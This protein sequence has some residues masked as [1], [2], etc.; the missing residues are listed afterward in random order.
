M[1][2]TPRFRALAL[3]GRRLSERRDGFATPASENLH[4]CGHHLTACG[5]LDTASGGNGGASSETD[6]VAS[7]A[8]R[9]III[10]SHEK[11]RGDVLSFIRSGAQRGMRWT[12]DR[13][14]MSASE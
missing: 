7:T 5:T 8:G 9:V 4:N 2:N 3:F 13:T 12:D 10:C 14:L 11:V 1:L 6:N